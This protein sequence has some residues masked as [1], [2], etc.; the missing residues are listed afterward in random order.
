MT[1]VDFMF[2]EK[3][4]LK[5]RDE[6]GSVFILAIWTLFFLASLAIAVASI[7]SS[8][9]IMAEELSCAAFGKGWS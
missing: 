3:I 1:R 6:S 7:V 4:K 9:L 5:E 8:N 2:T